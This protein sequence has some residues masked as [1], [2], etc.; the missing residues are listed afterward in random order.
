MIPDLDGMEWDG[1]EWCKIYHATQNGTQ[2]ETYELFISS[3]FHFI[4]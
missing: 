4:F 1:A 3:I 2:F